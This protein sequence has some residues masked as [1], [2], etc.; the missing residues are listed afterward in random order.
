MKV[1]LNITGCYK[2]LA[3][4]WDTC[5][6]YDDAPW[7]SESSGAIPGAVNSTSAV[8][9]AYGQVYL[10]HANI[11]YLSC[12]S[13]KWTKKTAIAGRT[14]TRSLPAVLPWSYTDLTSY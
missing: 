8:F 10:T 9:E 6:R 13:G 11:R 4:I 5:W 1:D 2:D 7:G 12:E 14:Y 3:L